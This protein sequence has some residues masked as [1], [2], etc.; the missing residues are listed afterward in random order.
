MIT[1]GT[2]I[3]ELDD[4]LARAQLALGL[5]QSIA[6]DLAEVPVCLWRGF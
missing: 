3:L 4:T 5:A 2:A 1:T 6:H